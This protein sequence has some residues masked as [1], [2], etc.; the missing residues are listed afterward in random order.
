MVVIRNINASRVSGIFFP[1]FGIPQSFQ[2]RDVMLVSNSSECSKRKT[3]WIAKLLPIRVIHRSN[4]CFE[5]DVV[6]P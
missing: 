3:E 1:F 4:S 5:K 2:T 6:S